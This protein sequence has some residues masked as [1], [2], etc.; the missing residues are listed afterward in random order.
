MSC[1]NKFVCGM[2][3][4]DKHRNNTN[5]PTNPELHNETEKRL[6][7][8]IQQRNQIDNQIFPLQNMQVLKTKMEETQSEKKEDNYYTPFSYSYK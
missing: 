5:T 6:Q 1:G 3:R 8:L 7:E 2:R 4:F